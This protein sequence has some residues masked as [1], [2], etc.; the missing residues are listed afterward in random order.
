MGTT[1]HG[2]PHTAQTGC[3]TEERFLKERLE[4]GDFR[5]FAHSSGITAGQRRPVPWQKKKH[6]GKMNICSVLSFITTQV[7]GSHYQHELGRH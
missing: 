3:D 7:T 6:D 4:H 5:H 1:D 2:L